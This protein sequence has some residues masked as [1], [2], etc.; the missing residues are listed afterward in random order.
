MPGLGSA[1]GHPNL[2]EQRLL[3][4]TCTVQGGSAY[5]VLAGNRA[6]HCYEAGLS[7]GQGAGFQFYVP[8]WIRYQASDVKVGLDQQGAPALCVGSRSLLGYR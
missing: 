6:H 1:A 2:P 7:A 3:S 8:P 4:P 5:W